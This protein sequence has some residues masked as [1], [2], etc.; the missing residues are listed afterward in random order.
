MR[1]LAQTGR[2][3]AALAA[4]VTCAVMSVPIALTAISG[5]QS[6]PMARTPE[7]RTPE[8]LAQALVLRAAQLYPWVLFVP[9]IDARVRHAA[10]GSRRR[11]AVAGAHAGA[12]AGVLVGHALLVGTVVFLDTGTDGRE[13]ASRQLLPDLLLYGSVAVGFTLS[14]TRRRQSEMADRLR[15]EL[16]EE[17]L[18]ALRQQ[19]NPH[20]L[21]N[22]LNQIVVQ[23]RRR[24]VESALAMVLALSDLLRHALR[25]RAQLIPM[26][27]E[28]HMV[29]R[30]LEV[31]RARFGERLEVVVTYEPRTA[32]VPVPSLL[33]QP[34]LENAMR[35]GVSAA[36]GTCKVWLTAR[37]EHERLRIEVRDAGPGAEPA[38]V[39]AGGGIGLKNTAERLKYLYGANHRLSLEPTDGGGLSVVI[40]LPLEEERP[41]A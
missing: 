31:E 41:C 35:H 24:D 7:V 13:L 17:R 1:V 4:G 32:D 27:D 15:A 20:F 10:A 14:D 2:T 40:D 3:R 6:R 38:V 5:G 19:L 34:L 36:E 8:T 29:E 12:L 21:F 30:Y 16:A 22:T 11:L 39:Q 18:E 28:L 23:M 25:E 33:L 26:R 37:V 9:L